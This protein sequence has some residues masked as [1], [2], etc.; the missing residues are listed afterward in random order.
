MRTRMKS[1]KALI[2]IIGIIAVIL[3]VHYFVV[4]KGRKYL[5]YSES[6]QIMGTFVN[7]DV[8]LASNEQKKV[9]EALKEV[10]AR[11]DEISSQMS[12]FNQEGV[13]SKIN[14]SQGSPMQ[15]EKDLYSLIKNSIYYSQITKGTFDVTVLPL[16]E[17]WKRNSREGRVP[18][19]KEI[20]ETKK[21][22]GY[23]YI[24]LLKGNK[25]QL[26]KINAK[27]DLGGIAKG[28]AVDEAARILKEHG[29]NNFFIDAGG[30]LYVSGLNCRERPWKIGIRDPQNKNEI[31]DVI[32]LSDMAV[33]TS[34]DYE[35][36]YM[37]NG[38]KYSHIIDPLTGYPQQGIVSATV[39]A[40]T[41]TQADALSTAL[42][43]LG[44][45]EGTRL[46]NSLGKKFAS[47]ILRPNKDLTLKSIQSTNYPKY[48]LDI[49]VKTK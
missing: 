42:C 25:I 20:N 8:C 47:L 11:M 36:F 18:T 40:P 38:K 48:R 27:V 19:Q 31:I 28:Y 41:A 10:W 6:R 23:K 37:I 46:I 9:D 14:N 33:T 44:E 32:E 30:D 13:L 45:N 3:A 34:G 12:V 2:I 4:N 24:Q 16:I 26:Q 5:K 17:L 22:V 29:I 49:K 39:I 1:K 15:I 43:V 35:Q 7:A 21:S